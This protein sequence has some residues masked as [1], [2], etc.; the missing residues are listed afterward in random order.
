MT[1]N[2]SQVAGLSREAALMYQA[3]L[4]DL[5]EALTS[6]TQAMAEK[7]EKEYFSERTF[8]AP[9]GIINC[10]FLFLIVKSC[11][12]TI[13][14]E[15]FTSAPQLLKD[16][17]QLETIKQNAIAT[18]P[19]E[20][21]RALTVL[22]ASGFSKDALKKL[23]DAPTWNMIYPGKEVEKKACADILA[24]IET[25]SLIAEKVEQVAKPALAAKRKEE[26]IEQPNVAERE[27]K[28]KNDPVDDAKFAQ[29]L[30]DEELAKSLQQEP[31]AK[32]DADA[33]FAA[34]LAEEERGYVE[35]VSDN[36]EPVQDDLELAR[37]LQHE[38]DERLSQLALQELKKKG[39]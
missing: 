7:R 27:K 23:F 37:A 39:K 10:F 33:A 25:L 12:A 31:Q 36:D 8:R 11:D 14:L 35:G 28:A 16:L 9:N 34:Q 13:R 15:A 29:E 32:I 1:A 4:K 3:N 26:A 6:T 30:H 20:V 5:K 18:K 2:V 21:K 17:Q 38:E 19:D 22:H 24:A